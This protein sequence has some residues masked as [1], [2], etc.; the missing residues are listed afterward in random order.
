MGWR[1]VLPTPGLLPVHTS[2]CFVKGGTTR[3]V[4]RHGLHSVD[5]GTHTC[6][7]TDALGCTGNATI[8]MNVMGKDHSY[9]I[10]CRNNI[11]Y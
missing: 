10:A 6:N 5:S 9:L 2:N 11:I 8:D 4:T 1:M 3:S 7:V